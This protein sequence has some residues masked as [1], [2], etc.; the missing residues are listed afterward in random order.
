[1]LH[2]HWFYFYPVLFCCPVRLA[3]SVQKFNCPVY[4]L[5]L[6]GWLQRGQIKLERYTG[7]KYVIPFHHVNSSSF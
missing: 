3:C 6:L 1:M 4:L 2:L 7:N 5:N